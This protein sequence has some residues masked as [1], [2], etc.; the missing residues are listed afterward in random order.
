MHSKIPMIVDH[1]DKAAL[2]LKLHEMSIMS[3]DTLGLCSGDES[4]E[5]V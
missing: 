4:D 3:S 5:E 2:T 1:T